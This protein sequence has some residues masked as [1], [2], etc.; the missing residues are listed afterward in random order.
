MI[1]SVGLLTTVI[2]EIAMGKNQFDGWIAPKKPML[3]FALYQALLLVIITIGVIDGRA[4]LY[5]QF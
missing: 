4:F 1:I 5:T 2:I 3:R